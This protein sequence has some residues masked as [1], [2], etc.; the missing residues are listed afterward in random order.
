MTD[1]TLAEM[2]R[3][4]MELA[5]IVAENPGVLAA[6]AMLFAG[7][8]GAAL[9]YKLW[10]TKPDMLDSDTHPGI[11]VANPVET[12]AVKAGKAE[13][14]KSMQGYKGPTNPMYG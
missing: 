1:P 2:L 8:A 11:S 3:Q 4:G 14:E 9:I 10:P 7:T 6:T 13:A 5:K 12:Q